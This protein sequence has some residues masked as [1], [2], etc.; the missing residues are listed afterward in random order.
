MKKFLSA[1]DRIISIFV[2]NVSAAATGFIFIVVT[3]MVIMRFIFKT[4]SLG[5]E[6]LPTYFLMIAI[7]LGTVICA[8]NP[9]EGLIKIDLFT[10]LLKKK[11]FIQ[12]II[13][14]ICSCFS[15]SCLVLFTYLMLQYTVFLFQNNQTTMALRVPLGFLTGLV[16]IAAIFLC[17]YEIVTLVKAVNNAK[18]IKAEGRNAA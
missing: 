11:P 8:R 3:F 5:F 18:D 4:S 2:D 1:A 10:G 17:I 16:F 13:S 6:E 15:L 14:C 7:W 12:A 9:K